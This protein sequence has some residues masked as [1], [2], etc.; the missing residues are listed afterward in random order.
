MSD[1]IIRPDDADFEDFEGSGSGGH[2]D[3]LR[4]KMMNS[5]HWCEEVM[6]HWEGYGA[7]K[8]F[9][10]IEIKDPVGW[11]QA[12]GEFQTNFFSE[13]ITIREFYRRLQNSKLK[14]STSKWKRQFGPYLR[15]GAK[16]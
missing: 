3:S 9:H 14:G 6:V 12:E 7:D 16:G 10:I 11:R 13:R 1:G 8:P 5:Q 2:R 15:G 4:T